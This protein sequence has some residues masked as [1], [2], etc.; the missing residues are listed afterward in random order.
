MEAK[1]EDP[2]FSRGKFALS[3][4]FNDM[5]ISK[6]HVS[7]ILIDEGV[8][9]YKNIMVGD[10]T[11]VHKRDRLR[12]CREYQHYTADDWSRYLQTDS[13]VWR[14]DG[15]RNSQNNRTNLYKGDTDNIR[16]YKKRKG[17]ETVHFYGGMSTEGLTELIRIR[18]LITGHRYAT[19]ILP[20]LAVKSLRRRHSNRNRRID[21]KLLFEHEHEVIFEQDFASVHWTPEVLDYL[22]SKGIEY[23]PRD[24]VCKLD[25]FW[26]I[27]RVW[28]IMTPIVYR[29]DPPKTAMELERRV[30]EAW[31]SIK[32]G[33]LKAIVHEMPCRIKKIIELKGDKIKQRLKEK[34]KCQCSFCVLWRTN[35][36]HTFVYKSLYGQEN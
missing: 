34:E 19:E 29:G 3:T 18:G 26:G 5:S 20:K 12:W 33:T 7:R 15:G 24:T 16:T 36:K 10:M 1:D 4:Y 11:I 6:S 27:E 9:A 28:A 2:D 8:Y 23:I 22:D 30:R 13:K 25:D 32:P 35:H 21:Q 31:K 14:L 17:G